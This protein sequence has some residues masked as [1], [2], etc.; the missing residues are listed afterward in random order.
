[1][2]GEK[3]SSTFQSPVGQ[4]EQYRSS[5][6]KSQTDHFK[7]N[8]ITRKTNHRHSRESPGGTR[9]TRKTSRPQA[10]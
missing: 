8:T 6:D 5:E 3:L 1:M 7:R 10:I 4:A 9:E 2:P